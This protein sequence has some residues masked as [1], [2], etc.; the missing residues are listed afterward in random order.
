MELDH[1]KEDD[2]IAD[3]MTEAFLNATSVEDDL[4][5]VIRAHIFIEHELR[6]LIEA[7]IPN[8]EHLELDKLSYGN[9]I[10]LV[11]ALGFDLRFK[12]SLQILGR[13]R[14]KFAH[15]LDMQLSDKD[16]DDIYRSLSVRDRELMATVDADLRARGKIAHAP[17]EHL[18]P[19]DRMWQCISC[20]GPRLSPPNRRSPRKP[21]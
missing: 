6:R 3:E 21:F 20:S 7:A 12:G 11:F 17:F 8:P 10:K 1:T 18:P 14:N 2:A 16:A 5:F 9:A 19:K 15:K 13:L 4:G